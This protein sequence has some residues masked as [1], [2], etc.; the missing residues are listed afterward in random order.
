MLT[1]LWARSDAHLIRRILGGH[2]NDFEIL[3]RRYLPAVLAMAKSI[4][5]NPADAED[6]A[7]E[8]FI[9]AYQKLDSLKAPEKFPGWLLSIARNN[10]LNWQRRQQHEIPLTDEAMKTLPAAYPEPAR[11][12]MREM[13]HRALMGLDQDVRELLL[14]HYYGGYSL[15]EIGG[16]YEI[17]RMAAAKRLQRARE[18]LGSEMLKQM[19]E[20]LGS[21]EVRRKSKKIAAAAFAAGVAWKVTPAHGAIM[22]LL[23]GAGKLAGIGVIALTLALAAFVAAPTALNWK[24]RFSA[25][26]AAEASAPQPREIAAESL[27]TAEQKPVEAFAQTPEPRYSLSNVLVTP[28]DQAIGGA[29]VKAELVTWKATELPPENTEIYTATAD[30]NGAFTLE[31]LPPGVYCV[32]AVTRLF[33]GAHDFHILENGDVRGPKNIKMYPV[34]RSYGLLVDSSGEPVPDAVIYPVSHELFP[35]REFDHVTVCGLRARSDAQGRFRFEGIIPGAW[36]LYIVAPGRQPFYTGYVPCYGLR[37]TVVIETPG[38][39]RGRIVDMAGNPVSG[40]TGMACVGKATSSYGDKEAG[41]R[42]SNTFATDTAGGFEVASLPPGEYFFVL[43][44]SALI[45]TSPNQKIRIASGKTAD[46]ELRVTEGGTV[47]GRVFNA[48]TGEGIAGISLNAYSNDPEA[49]VNKKVVTGATGDYI[50]TGLPSGSYRMFVASSDAFPTVRREPITVAVKQGETVADKDI[51]LVPPMMVKGVVL[52]AEGHPAQAKVSGSGQRE[53]DFAETE[54]DGTFMLAFAEGGA[55]TLFA[56]NDSFRSEPVVVTLN[57]ETP[58]TETVLT[59]SRAAG[60]GIEGFVRDINGK[61]VY[62][63]R[64]SA[65]LVNGEGRPNPGDYNEAMTGAQGGFKIMGLLPGK[66]A[67]TASMQRGNVLGTVNAE[68][69]SNQVT[70]DVIIRETPEGNL[71]VE[72]VIYYPNGLPCPVAAL[73]LDNSQLVSSGALGRFA[74]TRL[75]EGTHT[76]FALSPGYSPLAEPGIAAGTR[77]LKLVLHNLAV[78]TGSVSDAQT[79]KPVSDFSVRW[80][81]LSSPPFDTGGMGSGKA[82]FTDPKGYFRM[83]KIPVTPIRVDIQAANYAPWQTTLQELISGGENHVEAALHPAAGV[84][85]V[86]SDASGMPIPNV[87]LYANSSEAVSDANGRFSLE[88]LPAGEEVR[89]SASCPGYAATSVFTVAGAAEPVKVILTKGGTLRIRAIKDGQPLNTFAALVRYAD[90]EISRL[91]GGQYH[92]TQ[93]GEIVA[94]NIQPGEVEITT[95]APGGMATAMESPIGRATAI[96]AE[97]QETVAVVEELPAAQ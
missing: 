52:D 87:A 20:M 40:I 13:L 90:P 16:M 93:T 6:V 18:T 94:G 71:T 96:I 15:R 26:K 81:I 43:K 80:D 17:S 64:V 28:L 11:K 61:P 91:A 89:I 25:V 74:F 47:Y 14:L 48:K 5:H 37:S 10:A 68:V 21:S 97:D 76:I 53:N 58:E 73:S 30:E 34:L 33:G 83:E 66:Y 65:C 39:L 56:K 57:P 72:G 92:S 22:G 44:D 79:G 45:L 84:T 51:S 54:A 59:L 29:A 24:P 2:R 19:P 88:G 63:V 1:T 7:Q 46:A 12:E 85:G 86:V 8:C 95:L 60:G 50:F 55:I 35:N 3:V 82:G 67:V 42:M 62:N 77:D 70:P 69:G 49:R 9:A 31:G 75:G 4:L 27:E 36:K 23:I 78:L 41:Y 38:A 32:T